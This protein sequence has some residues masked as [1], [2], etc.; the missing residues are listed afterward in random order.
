MS[1]TA[2]GI[3][4][5]VSDKEAERFICIRKEGIVEMFPT[6]TTPITLPRRAEYIKAK[7]N[8]VGFYCGTKPEN[9][10]YTRIPENAAFAE[11]PE[12]RRNKYH[13]HYGKF[14]F[15]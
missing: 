10:G 15:F 5:E 3:D 7:R 2:Q 13:I 8:K 6:G 14:S 9:N 11:L 1:E 12:Y 4:A